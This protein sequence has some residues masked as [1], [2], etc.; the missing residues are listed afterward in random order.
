MFA[1]DIMYIR[2]DEGWLYLAIVPDLFNQDVVGENDQN[3]DVVI[4][5]G[6]R[7]QGHAHSVRN[8]PSKQRRHADSKFDVGGARD[9]PAINGM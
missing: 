1:S 4:N 7:Q 6:E 3:D 9:C 5:D 2:T 8:R